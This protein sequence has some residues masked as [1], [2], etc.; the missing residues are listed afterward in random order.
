M[1]E[2]KIHKSE[3]MLL[4]YIGAAL[5]RDTNSNHTPNGTLH[6]QPSWPLPVIRNRQ[7]PT[8]LR[9]NSLFDISQRNLRIM[10]M[11]LAGSQKPRLVA[12]YLNQITALCKKYVEN[13]YKRN[14][15]WI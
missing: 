9:I 14:C 6:V 5:V 8:R 1:E 11:F 4:Q 3:G 2:A 13:L 10:C 12:I 15:K 7:W